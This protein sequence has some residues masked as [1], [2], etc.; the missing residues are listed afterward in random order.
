MHGAV[1]RFPLDALSSSPA[2]A[3]LAS[4]VRADVCVVFIKRVTMSAMSLVAIVIAR[5]I[6][7]ASPQVFLLRYRLKMRRVAACAHMAQ[8]IDFQAVRN[9]TDGR[10]V[11][12]T[13]GND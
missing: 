13:M 9:A 5:A 2:L 4:T 12:K 3:A 11:C 1:Q 10:F 7:S 6:E 8:M